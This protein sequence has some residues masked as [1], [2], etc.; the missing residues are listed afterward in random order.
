MSVTESQA[1]S[2]YNE[3]FTLLKENSPE[4]RLD[5]QLP[6]EKFRQ[7]DNDFSEL[8]SEADIS[9]DQRYPSLTYNS[10]TQTVTVVTAP[11]SIHEGAA[12]WIDKEI[13]KFVDD[14]LSTRSPQTLQRIRQVG[15]TTMHFPSGRYRRSRK[16]PDGGFIYARLDGDDEMVIALEV[17]YTEVYGKLLD[18]KDMWINGMGVKV[19]IL[20]CFN[21]TPRFKYPGTAPFQ[22][23]ADRRAEKAA[24]SRT[25]GESTRLNIQNGYYG[26]LG[27]RGHEWVGEL[28]EAFIEVWRQGSHDRFDLIQEG[29]VARHNIPV[30]LGLRISD[31][32]PR[33]VW[34][35]EDIED[36]SITFDGASFLE[37]LR[38]DMM[39]T[40]KISSRD[41]CWRNCG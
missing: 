11:S 29:F 25:V 19:V 12:R 30:T 2:N 40:A 33:D 22:D 26:P 4:Q 10:L 23:I 28:T 16:E 8:K 5:I 1:V 15:S 41:S 27:Y 7:L 38:Y 24:M 18:D 39:T 32:Y 20:V 6:Y 35:D 34:Q 36:R 13:I 14:Y 9:E 3:A 17:G 37:G 21:E 31:L